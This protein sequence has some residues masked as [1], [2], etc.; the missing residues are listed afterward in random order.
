[1]K[2]EKFYSLLPLYEEATSLPVLALRLGL[3]KETDNTD[4]R[5]KSLQKAVRKLLRQIDLCT[6][7]GLHV[8]ELVETVQPST[9]K[10]LRKHGIDIRTDEKLIY[11]SRMED[12]K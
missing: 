8:I 3:V 7:K 11:Y 6:L 9:V 1:M 12:L 10:F 4:K 2:T 5:K